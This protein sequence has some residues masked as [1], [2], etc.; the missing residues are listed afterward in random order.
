MRVTAEFDLADALDFGAAVAQGAEVLKSLGSEDSLDARRASAVGEMARSQLAL[1][2]VEGVAQPSRNQGSPG[3][4]LVLHVHLTDGDP[5]A[6][7][8]RGNLA[9]IE[10]IQQWCGQSS[11]EVVVKPVIDLNEHIV[12]DGYHPSA[13]L[14]EQVILRDRT[15]VFPWCNRPSRACDL[16]HIIPWESGGETSSHNLAALCRRHHRLKTHGAWSYRRTGPAT[17]TWTSPHLRQGRQ[18]HEAGLTTTPHTANDTSGG[19]AGTSSRDL[20][21]DRLAAA[22]RQAAEVLVQVEYVVARSAVDRIPLAD[23]VGPD[24]VGPGKGRSIIRG[25][26]THDAPATNGLPGRRT[27]SGG[28]QAQRSLVSTRRPLAALA[29]QAQRSLAGTKSSVRSPV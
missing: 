12:C 11:T 3:R 16:D 20:D 14:R 6:R 24:L 21:P 23:G 1:P 10:Q 18:G 15:C 2:L 9:T 22:R 28:A 19:V 7:L 4:Q 29:T 13:R 26:R 5:I 17:Y 8:E 25:L 27:R